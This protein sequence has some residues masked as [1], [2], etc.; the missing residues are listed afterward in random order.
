MNLARTA[1]LDEVSHAQVSL[2]TR[3][4]SFMLKTASRDRIDGAKFEVTEKLLLRDILFVFQGIEG[5]MIRF[6]EQSDAYRI[7]PHIGVP[8]PIRDFID[9]LNELGW[10]FRKV[11]KFLNARVG[12]KALGLVGQSFCAALHK[13]L[14]EYYKLLAVLEAQQT[15]SAESAFSDGL[16]LRRLM[17]WT[18]DP[19]TRMKALATLV[20]LCKGI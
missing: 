6:D 12:D 1:E 18:N 15:Q 14:T 13:E 7:S 17:V 9:K 8:F 5:Q 2:P 10:L 20:D 4:G 16:T 11:R 3:S 19:F